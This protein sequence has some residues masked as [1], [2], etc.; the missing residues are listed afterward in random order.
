MFDLLATQ[1][2]LLLLKARDYDETERM[3]FRSAHHPD[4]R[5]QRDSVSR[6]QELL[7]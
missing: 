7:L 6:K 4:N 1:I 2:L 3:P 5:T